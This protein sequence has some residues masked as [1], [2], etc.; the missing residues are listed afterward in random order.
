VDSVSEARISP[1]MLDRFFSSAAIGERPSYGQRLAARL[2]ADELAAVEALYRRKLTG[3]TVPWR[4][5][6]AFVVARARA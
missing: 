1:A 5:V 3:T 4:S 6:T 2:S